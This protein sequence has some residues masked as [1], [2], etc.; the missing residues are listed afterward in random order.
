MSVHEIDVEPVDPSQRAA[1]AALAARAMRDNPMHVAGLGA[2]PDRR[3]RVFT[4][5]FTR[6][7]ALEGRPLLGAWHEGTLVGVTGWA[8]PGRCQP[9]VS[10]ARRLAPSLLA[11]GSRIPR[12]ALWFGAW[13]RRDPSVRHSHLGPVAVAPAWQGRGVGSALLA[14]HCRDLDVA[15]L[16]S[17]LETDKP[18]NV[19]FY[20]RFGY[21]V[22]DEATVIGATSWFMLR[23]SGGSGT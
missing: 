13:A 7:F 8:E 1:A 18:E 20:Q 10:D 2:D 21:R 23:P 14:A 11:A 5:L 9:S 6:L 12:L 15:G 4:A 3:T 16:P 22:T 17:H 19:R